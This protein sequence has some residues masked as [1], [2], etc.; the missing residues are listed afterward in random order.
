MNEAINDIPSDSS[1]EDKTSQDQLFGIGP[2]TYG[3][4]IRFPLPE[5]PSPYAIPEKPKGLEDMTAEEM[6]EVALSDRLSPDIYGHFAEKRA[7]FTKVHSWV[8]Y[9]EGEATRAI[10]G[11]LVNY[12]LGAN[13]KGGLSAVRDVLND[14]DKD[15]SSAVHAVSDLRLV[16]DPESGNFNPEWARENTLVRET[17]ARAVLARNSLNLF[18]WPRHYDKRT[19]ETKENRKTAALLVGLRDKLSKLDDKAMVHLLQKT[20]IHQQERLAFWSR[21]VDLASED[22]KTIDLISAA[23]SR[24]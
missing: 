10:G 8:P 12:L 23:R 17:L 2:G 20:L 5:A 7:D 1:E 22:E 6:I 4:T 14:V 9:S 13:D 24:A 15:R 18:Q 11:G 21:Q 19:K 16:Q 3:D